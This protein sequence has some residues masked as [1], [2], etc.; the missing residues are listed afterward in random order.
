MA[1]ERAITS[2]GSDRSMRIWKI[3]EESQLV[4]NGHSGSIDIVK[5]INEE[6]FISAGDDGLDTLPIPYMI[7][8]FCN[9]F[10][11]I[12]IHSMC[13][14]LC[15]WSAMKKKALHTK[16]LAHG[17][18]DDNDEANWISA[19]ATLINTDVVAS[20]RFQNRFML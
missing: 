8:D 10:I 17:K 9:L 14:S 2:G 15:L 3:V 18:S 16:Q 4:Y 19:V 1:R 11:Q 13:R 12:L 6:N 20:G 7:F 5:L